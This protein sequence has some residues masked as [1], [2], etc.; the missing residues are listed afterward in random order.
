MSYVDRDD[1]NCLPRWPPLWG[2]LL[3]TTTTIVCT[4]MHM[5]KK[6]DDKSEADLSDRLADLFYAPLHAMR[7]NNSSMRPRHPPQTQRPPS[8]DALRNKLPTVHG[9]RVACWLF[10]PCMATQCLLQSGLHEPAISRLRLQ[11]FVRS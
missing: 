3:S 1:L 11:H 4:P 8:E 5:Q 10:C 7:M 9:T 2:M 6:Q